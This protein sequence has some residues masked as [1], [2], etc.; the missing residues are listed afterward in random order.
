[1]MVEQPFDEDEVMSEDETVE[2]FRKEQGLSVAWGK[3]KTAMREKVRQ[4]RLLEAARQQDNKGVEEEIT[5]YSDASFPAVGGRSSSS[6]SAVA[7]NYCDDGVVAM[8][9]QQA[10]TFA[11]GRGIY[12]ADI[13]T[14]YVNAADRNN[15]EYRDEDGWVPVVFDDDYEME[16]V[17]SM[18]GVTLDQ[19]KAPNA[20]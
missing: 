15:G 17:A 14:G 16:L 10:E 18:N 11:L 3:Q 13:P 4:R 2:K 19:V 20:D 7:M 9:T 12:T 6:A 1:M 8:S 5:I